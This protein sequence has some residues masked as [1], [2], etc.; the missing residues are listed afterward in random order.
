M[1]ARSRWLL[2]VSRVVK[3]IPRGATASYGQVAM[4][5]GR[6]GGAR[7]VVRALNALS[8][9]PWWRVIRSDG[10]LAE[11]VRA[12]QSRRLAREGVRVEGG[13]VPAKARMSI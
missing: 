8:D 7:A 3:G 5:A 6:P 13:R 11:L 4:L 1:A 2:A 10:S 12:E 9:V